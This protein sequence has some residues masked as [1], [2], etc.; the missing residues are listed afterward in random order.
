M[1]TPIETI[2]RFGDDWRATRDVLNALATPV[3]RRYCQPAR[4]PKNRI[5]AEAWLEIRDKWVAALQQID[6]EVT[7][8]NL[9]RDNGRYNYHWGFYQSFVSSDKR[10]MVSLTGKNEARTSHHARGYY[11]TF[12]DPEAERFEFR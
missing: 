1:P 12:W 4:Y 10:Y 2:F 11:V 6:P 9:P 8:D 7:A 3:G 5:L